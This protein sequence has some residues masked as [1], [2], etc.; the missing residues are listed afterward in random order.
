MTSFRCPSQSV[1]DKIIPYIKSNEAR[2][3]FLPGRHHLAVE[4]GFK[5]PRSMDMDH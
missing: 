5:G 3:T 1:N 2:P 4:T